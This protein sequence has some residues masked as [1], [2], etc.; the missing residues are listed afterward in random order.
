MGNVGPSKQLSPENSDFNSQDLFRTNQR[1]SSFY[2]VQ[3]AKD[4]GI[5]F[6]TDVI[7]VGSSAVI[8]VRGI[9]EETDISTCAD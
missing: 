9:S 2:D 8:T 6:L 3:K 4:E 5:H 7:I 1:S